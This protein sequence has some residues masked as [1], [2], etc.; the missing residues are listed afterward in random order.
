MRTLLIARH[1]LSRRCRDR[2]ALITAF[3]APLALGLVFGLLIGNAGGGSF[4]IG[5]VTD[6]ASPVA[7][8]IATG[9]LGANASQQTVRFVRWP[10]RTARAAVTGG[11]VDAAIVLAPAI[12]RAHEPITV[13]RAAG[14]PIAGQVAE[15]I[16]TTAASRLAAIGVAARAAPTADAATM[17]VV[18][19]AA[20]TP[21][22]ALADRA[23]GGSEISFT[24][25][26]GASMSIVFLFFTV[27]SASRSLLEERRLGT[28][29]RVRSTP[30]AVGSIVAGKAL[31]VSVL[32]I[33][34]LTTVW[35]ATTVVFDARW[36]DP[37]G[38]AALIVATV[39]AIGGV[40]TLVA[41]F[42]RTDQQ[43]ATVTAMVTFGLALVG[44]NFVG[45]GRGPA[46]LRP[47]AGITPNGLAL[48]GFGDL[49]ADAATFG[50]VAGEVLAL[51][52]IAVVTGTI[53]LVR[54]QRAAAR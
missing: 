18:A 16:A 33:A 45:P 23:L 46:V 43:A 12:D 15:S 4:R 29:A 9:L 1:E 48:R 52:A 20:A 38:V 13:L 47:L 35:V 2:S 41:S 49:S 51:V 37:P 32:G 26:Y 28:L 30:T 25:F 14:R 40:A 34:G 44:G 53:G 5:V 54:V 31:A 10:A 21:A 17:M 19:R 24:A 22:I 8:G 27:G 7:A 11:D 3:I 6:D 42:A 39:L 50:T 36:G